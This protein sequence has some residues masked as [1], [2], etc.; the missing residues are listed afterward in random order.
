MSRVKIFFL[1]L[2]DDDDDDDDSPMDLL[3]S[4]TCFRT[5]FDPTSSQAFCGGILWR[6]GGNLG[7]KQFCTR[8]ASILGFTSHLR[9]FVSVIHGFQGCSI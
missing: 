4:C 8:L 1:H 7:P 2:N 5:T 9:F 6:S 3:L